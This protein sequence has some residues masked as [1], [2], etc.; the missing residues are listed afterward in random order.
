[1]V[2][3][4]VPFPTQLLVQM[5]SRQVV[6]GGCE[7]QSPRTGRRGKPSGVL[8]FRFNEREGEDK[9]R[10]ADALGTINGRRVTYPELT[11]KTPPD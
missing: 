10:F 9:D 8:H 11:G 6:S 1:M 7:F 2:K 3:I 4:F 5:L